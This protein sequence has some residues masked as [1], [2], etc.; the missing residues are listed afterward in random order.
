MAFL[1]CRVYIGLPGLQFTNCTIYNIEK[2]HFCNI[3]KTNQFSFI[4]KYKVRTL[5]ELMKLT[6]FIGTIFA[7][8]NVNIL[9]T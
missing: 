9:R 2:Y 4:V 6:E 7:G 5:L 3:S 8:F 1:I